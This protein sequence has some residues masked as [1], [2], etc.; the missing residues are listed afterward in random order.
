MQLWGMCRHSQDS[1]MITRLTLGHL[2]IDCVPTCAHVHWSGSYTGN[3]NQ[4]GKRGKWDW[5]LLGP[6]W[7]LAGLGGVYRSLGRGQGNLFA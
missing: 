5:R 4:C 3:V 7:A 6:A 2:I 1:T